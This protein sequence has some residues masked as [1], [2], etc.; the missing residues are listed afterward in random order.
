MLCDPRCVLLHSVGTHPLPSSCDCRTRR[1]ANAR[2]RATSTFAPEAHPVGTRVDALTGEVHIDHARPG[3]TIPP[4][5]VAS[6]PP[7]VLELIDALTQADQ[8]VFAAA[9][10]RLISAAAAAERS[11]GLPIL[12]PERLE[13][14]VN[15]TRYIPRLADKAM[16][17]YR[18]HPN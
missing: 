5:S 16:A 9:A 6:L 14:F 4:H 8:V 11:V 1:D 3:E 13:A 7:D 17:A 2:R 18:A 10:L 15:S 12:C